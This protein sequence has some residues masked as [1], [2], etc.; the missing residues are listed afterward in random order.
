MPCLPL[1]GLIFRVVVSANQEIS[2]S[3]NFLE[4]SV[5]IMNYP[6]RLN[7]GDPLCKNSPKKVTGTL[8][9]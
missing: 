3:D 7:N 9:R 1:F 2:D 8:S 5:I 4:L 6:L